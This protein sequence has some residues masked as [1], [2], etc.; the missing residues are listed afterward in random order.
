[1]GNYPMPTD[2]EIAQI[3]RETLARDEVE[4]RVASYSYDAASGRLTL[5]LRGPQ[6]FPR[7]P[8]VSFA[9]RSVRGLEDATDEQL[10]T[11]ELVG[12]GSALHWDALDVQATTIALLQI[13]FKLR[14]VQDVARK[15]GSTRSPAKAASAAQNGRKGGRPRKV[16]QAA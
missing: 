16:P 10:G 6:E 1:M 3:E 9:A 14:S 11:I 7:G 8:S 15:A 5:H 2:E 12:N 13:V 4:P